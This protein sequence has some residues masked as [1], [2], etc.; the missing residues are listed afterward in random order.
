MFYKSYTFWI[1]KKEIT[2]NNYFLFY[3]KLKK[4]SKLSLGISHALMLASRKALNS[5]I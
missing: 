2:F 3:R 1:S 4:A 5:R